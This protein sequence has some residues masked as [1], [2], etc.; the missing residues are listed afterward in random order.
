[1]TFILFHTK[2]LMNNTGAVR[3]HIMMQDSWIIFPHLQTTLP[4]MFTEIFQNLQII[5]FINSS[6]QWH[7]FH[8]KRVIITLIFLLFLSYLL[9]SRLSS[10]L[11]RFVSGVYSSFVSIQFW[12]IW[13]DIFFVLP[14]Q[15]FDTIF[16]QTLCIPRFFVK[17]ICTVSWLILRCSVISHIFKSVSSYHLYFLHD[18]VHATSS[19]F[20]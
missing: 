15:F 4:Y 7:K 1:M 12:A 19:A 9:W 16:V 6:A 5:F 17:I 8:V 10:Q 3:E 11:W 2:K 18:R 13:S 20:K 14:I